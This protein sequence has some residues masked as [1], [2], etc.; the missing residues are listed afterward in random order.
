LSP[1]P[2]P[3][4]SSQLHVIST[5]GGAFA[6]VVESPLYFAVA[7]VFAVAV[8]AAVVVALAFLVVIP[9]RGTC[10]CT[11]YRMFSSKQ[12]RIAGAPSSAQFHR[13]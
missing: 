2:L 6:A 5:E 3:P 8:A 10:C 9:R 12:A 1:F 13:A 7:V 11:Y 4:L